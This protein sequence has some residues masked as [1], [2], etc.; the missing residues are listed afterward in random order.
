[1]QHQ[2][3][4]RELSARVTE[5]YRLSD[6]LRLVG[7]NTK[8]WYGRSVEG[9]P[10]ELAGHCGLVDYQPSELVVRVRD[11]TC[12]AEIEL[13]LLLRGSGLPVTHLFLVQGPR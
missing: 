8:A 10:L 7:G 2:D 9:E 13:Y 12:L 5:A 6:P 1:M 11:G 4:S 3:L